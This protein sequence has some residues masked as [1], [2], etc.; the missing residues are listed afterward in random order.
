MR[1]V[2]SAK[3]RGARGAGWTGKTRLSVESIVARRTRKTPVSLIAN[4]SVKWFL[5]D[6]LWIHASI[7]VGAD[8]AALSVWDDGISTVGCVL[9]DH[10]VAHDGST[11][12][13]ADLAGL[14]FPYILI[15]VQLS[16]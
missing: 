10:L 15:V 11:V 1:R 16:F 6:W 3:A 13:D 5:S 7:R 2:V 9:A 12:A 8:R 4:A 14:W